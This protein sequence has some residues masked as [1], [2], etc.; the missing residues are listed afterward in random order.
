MRV[1]DEGRKEERRE[2]REARGR[3][4]AEAEGDLHFLNLN[5]EWE[6]WLAKK[7]WEGDECG[8]GGGSR[9]VITD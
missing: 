1:L 7:V 4:G 5:V 2:G 3:E 8:G 9:A 6:R